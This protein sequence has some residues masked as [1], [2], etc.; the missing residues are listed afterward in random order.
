MTQITSKVFQYIKPVS[1]N[2]LDYQKF[3][4]FL[5]WLGVDGGVYWWLF[6]DYERR[7]EINGDI[8]NTKSENITKKIKNAY[9]SVQLVAEDLSENE[10]NVLSKITRAITVRRYYKDGTFD[11]LAIKTSEV[12]KSK[13]QFRYNIVLSVEEIEDNIM[14]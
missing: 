13:S 11:D 10:F 8:V 3:E 1:S 5:L 14:K 2:D 4:Y 7:K 12:I 9:N 6:E